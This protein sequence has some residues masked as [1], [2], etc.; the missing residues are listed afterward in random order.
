ML[1][2]FVG[3]KADND[4]LDEAVRNH[5]NRQA[6]LAREHLPPKPGAYVADVPD[7]PALDA[8][9][10]RREDEG[11]RRGKSDDAIWIQDEVIK[12]LCADFNV[13]ARQTAHG[14]AQLAD[15]LQDYGLTKAE[16]LQVC[17]LGPRSQVGLYLV[18]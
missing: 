12:Y 10:L 7:V 18:S 3:I 8:A 1:Q 9:G 13:A 2:H 15:G 11:A 6:L 4:F 14:I 17:N 16:L 5:T